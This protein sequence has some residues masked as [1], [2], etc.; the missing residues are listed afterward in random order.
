MT[1][2]APPFVTVTCPLCAGVAGSCHACGGSRVVHAEDAYRIIAVVN[3]PRHGCRCDACATLPKRKHP[4]G[5]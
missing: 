2:D 5:D 3:V 4:P 1:A